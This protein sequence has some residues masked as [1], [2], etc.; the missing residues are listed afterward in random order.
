MFRTYNLPWYLKAGI[1][2]QNVYAHHANPESTLAYSEHVCHTN[3]LRV[4]VAH[5]ALVCLAAAPA[6]FVSVLSRRQTLEFQCQVLAHMTTQA[7]LLLLMQRSFLS[8]E[9]VCYAQQFCASYIF[10]FMW[11]E[12]RA[13]VALLTPSPLVS[14]VCIIG[15]VVIPV[16]FSKAWNADL[17]VNRYV[18]AIVFSGEACGMLAYCMH[19]TIN[20]IA[21]LGAR[22][23]LYDM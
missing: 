20:S 17:H 9:H 21:T 23:N 8:C 18:L 16:C 12:V 13:N 1:I 5:T 10:Y 22:L 7:I 11:Q 19:A 6:A 14:L 2:L 15:M 4:F 3:L